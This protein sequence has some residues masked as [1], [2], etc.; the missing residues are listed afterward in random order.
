MVFYRKKK[1]VGDRDHIKQV[2]VL[3]KSV[4]AWNEWRAA[5]PEIRHVGIAGAK[6]RRAKLAGANLRGATLIEAGCLFDADL[7]VNLMQCDMTEADLRLAKKCGTN[8][9]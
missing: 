7:A 8:D 4:V 5:N 1:A 3:R 9:A 6:L 2:A